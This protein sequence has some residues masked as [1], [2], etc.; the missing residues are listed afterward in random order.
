[1][2][3][4]TLQAIAG[5]VLVVLVG[6][7]RGSGL[8]GDSSPLKIGFLATLSGPSSELGVSGRNAVAMAVRLVNDAGGVLG[9]PL[10]IVTKDLRSTRAQDVMGQFADEGVNF[11]IGPY[12]SDGMGF[13]FSDPRL[14]VLSPTVA[15]RRLEGIDDN[16]VR[17]I[18]PAEAQ[19]DVLAGHVG[20]DAMSARIAIIADSSNEAYS[21]ELVAAFK[22]GLIGPQKEVVFERSYQVATA[23]DCA[24]WSQSIHQLRADTILIV[25]DAPGTAMMA[26]QLR[27]VGWEGQ[28]L[29]GMWSMTQDLQHYGGLAVEG[30]IASG[31]C[32]PQSSVPR[33]AAFREDYVTL[34]GTEPS[35]SA[36]LSYEAAE[37]LFQAI[38][39]SQSLDPAVIKS[40][41]V[42]KQLSGLQSSY[43]IDQYG[44][45]QR[46][47][48]LFTVKER[49]FRRLP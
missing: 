13:D 41:L 36:V 38:A 11:V 42:G 23:S 43:L 39:D 10:E 26:Q 28:I 49:S 27:K 25:C 34:Y 16:L 30:T 29:T 4:R 37:A 22:R 44:D 9:R 32:D 24:E 47:Y 12:R 7:N 35:F 33:Y 3:R 14:L 15:N 45:P 31:I 2:K 21:S 48:Q 17:F 18:E 5:I 6:V 40:A 19:G 8:H 1:M 46:P 20:G